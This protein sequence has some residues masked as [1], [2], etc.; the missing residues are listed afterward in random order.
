MA[1]LLALILGV[2]W[3]PI[4]QLNLC[5]PSKGEALHWLNELKL[6]RVRQVRFIDNVTEYEQ[7]NKLLT[8]CKERGINSTIV[9]S[10]KVSK[11]W[12]AEMISAGIDEFIIDSNV[13]SSLQGLDFTKVIMLKS[14]RRF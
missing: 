10:D 11:D 12:F 9:I 3:L 1:I 14:C 8:H 6:N 13:L 4:N 2:I 5:L 7:L